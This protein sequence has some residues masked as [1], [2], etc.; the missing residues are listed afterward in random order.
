MKEIR[1][2]VQDEVSLIAGILSIIYRDEN[3]DM[4]LQGNNLDFQK[5]DTEFDFEIKNSEEESGRA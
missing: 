2:K 5:G 1:I 3:G 4:R